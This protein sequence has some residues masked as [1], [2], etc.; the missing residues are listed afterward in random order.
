MDDKY[1]KSVI[2]TFVKLYNDGLIYQGKRMINWDPLGKTAL[3]NEEVIYKEEKGFLWH[4]KYPI[5]NEKKYLIVATTRPETMLGDTGVAVN[6]NDK[7][8]SEYIGKKVLLPIMN[9]EIPIFSDEYVDMDFGTGCV[10]V[11]PAHDMNDYAMA[12]RNN[13]QIIN[14]MHDDATFNNNVPS[15]FQNKDR[16]EVRKMVL[17]ILEKDGYLL[18]QKII[19]IKLV[20]LKEQMQLLNL[21]YLSNGF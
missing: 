8:Y 16:F 17:E 1:Y 3:S 7:R 15:D 4:I 13:L 9:K 12:N 2:Q 11:T 19:F 20:I 10:K 21:G 5:K 6:P 14:I 18:K